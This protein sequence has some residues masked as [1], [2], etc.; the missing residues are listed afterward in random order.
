MADPAIGAVTEML[1]NMVVSIAAEKISLVRGMKKELKKLQDQLEMVRALLDQAH[2]QPIS[3][4]P[5][6]LWLEKLQSVSLDAQIVLEEFGYEVL[7]QKIEGRK[8]RD[9]LRFFVSCST[10]PLSFR[11]KMAQK[12]KYVLQRIEDVYAEGEVSK[13]HCCRVKDWRSIHENIEAIHVSIDS[14]EKEMWERLIPLLPSNLRTLQ[15]TGKCDLPEDLFKKCTCLTV[16]I[17]RFQNPDAIKMENTYGKLK[18]L[19]YLSIQDTNLPKTSLPKSFTRLYYLQTLR[20]YNLTIVPDGFENLNNLRHIDV[21]EL[22]PLP[23]LGQL[24][25][26]QTISLVEWK[27]YQIEELEHLDSLTG[28]VKLYSLQRL[29]SYESAVKSNLSRKPGIH[30]L[31]FFW[32][33]ASGKKAEA[34]NDNANIDVT[35]EGLKPHPNLKRLIIK[36]F[37]I[38]KFPSWMTREIDMTSSIRN[39]AI[40]KLKNLDKCDMLPSLGQLPRLEHLKIERLAMVKRIGKEFYIWSTEKSSSG[41]CPEPKMVSIFPALKV[42]ELLVM[43]NL[44]EWEDAFGIIPTT[45]SSPTAQVRAFPSLEKLVLSYLPKL[46]VLPSLGSMRSLVELNIL[47]LEQCESLP[48]L[49]DLPRLENLQINGL[50]KAKFMREEVYS[51]SSQKSNIGNWPETVCVFP[52]LR[53]FMMWDMDNLE[54][55]SIGIIPASSS[56]SV[57]LRVFPCLEE[58]TLWAVPKFRGFFQTNLAMLS[59]DVSNRRPGFL[60]ELGGCDDREKHSYSSGVANASDSYIYQQLLCFESLQEL[61]MWECDESSASVCSCIPSSAPLKSLD[62]LCHPNSWPKDLHH[63][64]NLKE[65]C[66]GY[67]GD[68]A[69]IDRD[70]VLPWPYPTLFSTRLLFPSL[71]GLLHCVDSQESSLYRINCNIWIL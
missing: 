38:L 65:L 68:S 40:L 48:A 64:T 58:M 60:K 33:D 59:D 25:N 15:L 41:S 46:G 17:I 27:E 37:P 5:I 44:V 24:K 4:K 22:S 36:D 70:Y 1:L 11:L 49:G 67:D 32:L 13:N 53:A 69:R 10:N 66:L 2:Q 20:A 52:A 56:S 42:L 55:W 28:E 7:R 50:P 26:L 12:I 30:T 39:L 16:L 19:R 23:K 62:I 8:R 21:V 31:K 47:Y 9:K 63:L 29:K 18:H 35:M 71:S 43:E 45:S 61:R 57:K 51:W 14:W 34:D 54:E 6:Q 3:N